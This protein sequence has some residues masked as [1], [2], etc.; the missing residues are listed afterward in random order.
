M[1]GHQIP[2]SR[3][4]GLECGSQRSGQC[5]VVLSHGRSTTLSLGR[6]SPGAY[7]RDGRNTL[8][9]CFQGRDP[10]IPIPGRHSLGAAL[11]SRPASHLRGG[12]EHQAKGALGAPKR[13][14]YRCSPMESGIHH[15]KQVRN[16]PGCTND[17]S[18]T[19]RRASTQTSSSAVRRH[20]RLCSHNRS[21]NSREALSQRECYGRHLHN[22]C[23]VPQLRF[24]LP[25]GY[26]PWILAG[27]R[28]VG[29]MTWLSIRLP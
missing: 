25:H 15:W 1:I 18:G 9:G 20:N 10:G 16:V 21:G 2:Q 23:S 29:R 24:Q 6:R 7:G 4:D 11:Y 12:L 19:N 5:A 27:R 17:H 13:E 14:F 8:K 28:Q 26:R 22:G 3:M